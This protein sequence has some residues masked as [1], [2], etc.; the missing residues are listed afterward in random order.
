MR[1]FTLATPGGH[2]GVAGGHVGVAGGQ[3]GVAGGDVGVG[4]RSHWRRLEVTLA[5]AGGQY[6]WPEMLPK[7][8][9]GT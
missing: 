6:R 8:A 3:I 1:I 2:V 4:R 9:G 5:S 7:Q